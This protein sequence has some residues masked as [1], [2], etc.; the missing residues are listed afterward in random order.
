MKMNTWKLLAPTTRC[1]FSTYNTV[2]GQYQI[3]HQTP[4]MPN[5]K[6]FTMFHP[7]G[8]FLPSVLGE[9]ATEA[10][11]KSAVEAHDIKVC[12]KYGATK[13]AGSK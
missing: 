12:A 1:P 10:E 13:P 2:H 4:D 3:S 11:A 6:H 5:P 8:N 7:R 9:F